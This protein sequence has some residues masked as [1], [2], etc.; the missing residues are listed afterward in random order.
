MK[1][2]LVDYARDAHQLSLTAA[3]E[4]L[5]MSPSVHRYR[6]TADKDLPVVE[7]IQQVIQEN[8]GFRFP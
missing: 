7:A 6:P 5:D 1:R 4:L 8:P 2:E 3:C